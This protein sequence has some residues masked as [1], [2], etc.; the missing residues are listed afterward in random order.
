MYSMVSAVPAA[1][2]FSSHNAHSGCADLQRELVVV[3]HLLGT[4]AE[5]LQEQVVHGAEVVVHELGF[6]PGLL[7]D[8]SRRHRRVALVAH[9]LFGGVEQ[10]RAVLGVGRA[11]PAGRTGWRH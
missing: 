11:Q 6:E 2:V 1:S 10:H 9:Q 4:A 3:Q 7:G 5:H 8:P